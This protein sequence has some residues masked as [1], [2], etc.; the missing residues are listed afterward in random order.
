[1]TPKIV[2]KQIL[3]RLLLLPYTFTNILLKKQNKREEG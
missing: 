2:R 1:M 3:V